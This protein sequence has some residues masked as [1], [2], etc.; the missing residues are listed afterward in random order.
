MKLY[1][2]SELYTG[3]LNQIEDGELE[4]EQME[5]ALNVI[6]GEFNYKAENIVKII[7][8]LEY[9][10]EAVKNETKRLGEQKKRL[11]RNIDS[12]K[13]YLLD[14]M[15]RTG[16]T[17]IKS[18]LFNIGIR[19]NPISVDVYDES[20]FIKVAKEQFPNLLKEEINIKVD[21]KGIKDVLS[22]DENLNIPGVKLQRTKDLSIK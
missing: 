3:I 1:E 22:S 21:K 13:N 11:E 12:L 9:S 18:D 14:N 20:E 5:E 15:N 4:L 10:V 8:S 2:I 19:N 17:K 7:K 6:E 16:V